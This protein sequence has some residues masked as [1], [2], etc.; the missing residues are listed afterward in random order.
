ML[1]YRVEAILEENRKP[2]ARLRAAYRNLVQ[3]AFPEKFEGRL[4]RIDCRTHRRKTSGSFDAAPA[5]GRLRK[6]YA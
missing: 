3:T 2:E 5:Q 4:H 6:A 1:G